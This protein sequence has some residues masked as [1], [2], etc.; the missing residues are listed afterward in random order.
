M[1]TYLITPRDP[2]IFRDGRPFGPGERANSHLAMPP[3]VLAGMVRTVSGTQ[4]GRFD[5][6]QD[7]QKLLKFQVRGPVLVE[8]NGDEPGEWLIAPPLDAEPS[9]EGTYRHMS[10][11]DAGDQT[12]LPYLL[13]STDSPAKVYEPVPHWP[14]KAWHHWLTRQYVSSRGEVVPRHASPQEDTRTHVQINPDTGTAADNFLFQTSARDFNHLNAST[15]E[16]TSFGLLFQSDA[17]LPEAP[18]VSRLGGEGRLARLEPTS[19]P[20]PACPDA[21]LSAAETDGTL[22][23]YLVTPAEFEKGFEPTWLMQAHPDVKV[24]LRAIATSRPLVLSGWNMKDQKAKPSRR[25]A[26]AGS[27]YYLQ[28]EGKPEAKRLWAERMWLACVSDTEQ[29]RRDGFG[30]CLV[31]LWDRDSIRVLARDE[32]DADFSELDLSDLGDE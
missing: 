10:L 16:L 14:W 1:K 5:A 22:T 24:H 20:W 17:P 4:D 11:V 25:F 23:V 21:V 31:G 13:L 6:T 27:A 12:D 30:L 28:L 26:Q 9:G 15:G 8:L 32:D 3:S 19:T 7:V 29:A 18:T 2:L